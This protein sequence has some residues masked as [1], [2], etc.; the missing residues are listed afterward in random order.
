M[1][2][3]FFT[4]L[5]AV[6]WIYSSYCWLQNCKEYLR[7]DEATPKLN[8]LEQSLLCPAS[9]TM[10]CALRKQLTI[11][12]TAYLWCTSYLWRSSQVLGNPS[13]LN[14]WRPLRIFQ[15]TVP[16][17]SQFQFFQFLQ[18]PQVLHPCSCPKLE[19]KWCNI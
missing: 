3:S 15:G 6:I 18:V 5:F 2:S 1:S 17:L 19:P 16:Y 13:G 14:S 8:T 11:W 4:I 10:I 7:W 9:Y 12:P